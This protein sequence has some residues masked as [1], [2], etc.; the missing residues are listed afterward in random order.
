MHEGSR[1]RGGRDRSPRVRRSH[2][3][4]RGQRP[5]RTRRRRCRR[6][7]RR[8]A[9]GRAGTSARPRRVRCGPSPSRS[10][11]AGSNTYPGRE[12]ATT[13]KA[14]PAAGLTSGS[15]RCRNSATELGK[16][17]VISSG[18]APGLADDV[19]EVDALA[20]DLGG[21]LWVLVEPRLGGAPVVLRAPVL[22]QLLSGS[23]AERRGSTPR[24]QARPA[25]GHGRAGHA[26]TRRRPR[27]SR[28]GRTACRSSRFSLSAGRYGRA[29][30]GDSCSAGKARR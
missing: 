24:R 27:G 18:F 12:G 9:G 26:G 7:A 30:A 23:P 21:E 25:S 3:R 11:P 6:H 28:Y 14:W 16:P 1:G 20:V 22:G 13:W 8:T 15:I 19:Q 2:D 5:C 4:G 10:R 29:P 17:L